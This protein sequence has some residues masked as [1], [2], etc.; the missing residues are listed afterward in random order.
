MAQ[1]VNVE[2]RNIIDTREFDVAWEVLSQPRYTEITMEI[3]Y[4][5]ADDDGMDGQGITASGTVAVEGRT[6]AMGS[7][8]PLGTVIWIEGH[9]YVNEDRGGYIVGNRVDVF[10]GSRSVAMELG[11]TMKT[12]KVEIQ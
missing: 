3:S 1:P 8:Y 4:Y 10:V 9:R 7:E 6:V 12:V 11:R 2:A 5:T